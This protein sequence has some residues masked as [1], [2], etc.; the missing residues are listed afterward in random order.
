M[1][2]S[3]SLNSNV[4]I[5]VSLDRDLLFAYPEEIIIGSRAEVKEAGDLVENIDY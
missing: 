1:L 5:A 2:A 3:R 4:D